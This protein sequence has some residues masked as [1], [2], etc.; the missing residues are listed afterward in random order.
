MN[1]GGQVL[2]FFHTRMQGEEM[3]RFRYHVTPAMMWRCRSPEQ[4]PIQRAFTNRSIERLFAGWSRPPAVPRQ[5]Q[6]VRSHHDAVKKTGNEGAEGRAI[7]I[8]SSLSQSSLVLD[9]PSWRT[10]ATAVMPRPSLPAGNRGCVFIGVSLSQACTPRR[11]D[12]T[13]SRHAAPVLRGDE[14]ARAYRRS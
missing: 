1:P 14:G 7:S 12:S 11:T 4:F 9:P 2:A 10:A 3:V 13:R 5:G 6:R 8:Q